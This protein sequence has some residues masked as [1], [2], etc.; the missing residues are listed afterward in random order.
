MMGRIGT[1]SR[2]FG[3][4]GIG[5][6]AMLMIGLTGGQSLVDPVLLVNVLA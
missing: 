6:K 5:S 3:V 4:G 1:G 2:G